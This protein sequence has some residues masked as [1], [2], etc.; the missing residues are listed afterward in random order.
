MGIAHLAVSAIVP[1]LI[2]MWYF[3]QRDVFPEPPRVLWTTF[4]LGIAIIVPV[5]VVAWPLEAIAASF[6]SPLAY[7]LASAFLTAAIPEE[8][9]KFLVLWRYAAR[10]AEFDEPMDGVV[11]GVAASLGFAT[12]ENVLYVAE[13]GASVA[14][15]RAL[16]AVPCHAFLGAIMGYFVGRAKFP[17]APGVEARAAGRRPLLVRA[18]AIP[19]LLHGLYDWPLLAADRYEGEPS[20]PLFYVLLLGVP[21]IVLG[22]AVWSIRMGRRLRRAQRETGPPEA[23]AV[24][25]VTPIPPPPP[26]IR[27]ARERPAEGPASQASGKVLGWISTVTGAVTASG[28]GLLVLGIVA[29]WLFYGVAPDEAAPLLLGTVLFGVL[30][31]VLGLL[32]FRWGVLRLNRASR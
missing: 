30:P 9:F 15:V 12:L 22:Q 25:Q 20:D 16:S 24:A 14:V 13:G 27:T 6:A 18:L 26:P 2:L 8:L 3:H 23:P 31:L 28:G 17:E 11:Y 32:L 4:G 5:L 1:S 29:G 21:V 10:R 19:I 7:G